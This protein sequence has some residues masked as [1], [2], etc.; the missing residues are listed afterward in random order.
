M[1]EAPKTYALFAIQ[2]Y[3][4]K[5]L[6]NAFLFQ[7]PVSSKLSSANFLRQF[8]NAESRELNKLSAVQFME[9]WDHYDNDGKKQLD[10]GV[11]AKYPE[12]FSHI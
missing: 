3:M 6:L 11:G 1:S 7:M 5:K 8:R 4:K 9:V 12:L 2:F 10:G